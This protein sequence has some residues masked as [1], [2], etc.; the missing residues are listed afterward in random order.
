MAVCNLSGSI[1]FTEAANVLAE[2][3]HADEDED[4]LEEEASEV[5]TDEAEGSDTAVQRTDAL[6]FMRARLWPSATATMRKNRT[7]PAGEGNMCA[8]SASS[9][10]ANS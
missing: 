5:E 10:P 7:R 1:S 6:R 8:M 2:E 4:P 9:V 3:D